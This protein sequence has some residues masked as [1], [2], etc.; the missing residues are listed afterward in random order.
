MTVATAI[1][2]HGDVPDHQT[3]KAI[4]K[5]GL[6]PGSYSL[7]KK[8][9][10]SLIQLDLNKS[11]EQN[12]LNDKDVIYFLNKNV[13]E[14]KRVTSFITKEHSDEKTKKS[15][16]FRSMLH[17]K[18]D[19]EKQD[20]TAKCQIKVFGVPLK[21]AMDPE[22][23]H[24]AD[25]GIP[26]FIEQAFQKIQHND[27]S[28]DFNVENDPHVISGLIKLFLRELPEPLLTFK[29]FK[30]FK[31]L[32][33]KKFIELRRDV[34][35]DDIKA[36]YCKTCLSFLPKENYVFLKR[37]LEFFCA[38]NKFESLNKMSMQNIATILGPNILR[39]ENESGIEIMTN[40]SIVNY[41]VMFM[42]QNFDNLFDKNNLSIPFVGIAEAQYAFEGQGQPSDLVFQ[43]GDILF[44]S[45]C[46]DPHGW[47]AGQNNGLSGSFPY[48]FVK[49]LVQNVSYTTNEESFDSISSVG[50][51]EVKKKRFSRQIE[52][53]E[54][55]SQ[56]P[57]V[58]AKKDEDSILNTLN[59]EVSRRREL[60][61][62][63]NLLAQNYE[64]LLTRLG[65]VEEENKLLKKRIDVIE[66]DAMMFSAPP[67]PIPNASNSSKSIG[68][69]S[70]NH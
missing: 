28:V 15:S 19:K 4:R 62:I 17:S 10:T 8:E 29:L 20:S 7:H 35:S 5:L 21:I 45:D 27:Q 54:L 63:I 60:E 53:E 9:G 67:P 52:P 59:F 69:S 50:D 22:L 3:R 68:K 34:E 37:I 2:L 12:G 32:H 23:N 61:K 56:E 46:C 36:L 55:H 66:G 26:L 48:N 40:T 42:L 70:S 51:D 43:E 33:C 13:K 14:D 24:V 18:R 57:I 38:L 64:M 11:V 25:N 41:V 49:M 31:S 39:P 16:Y 47:W 30:A 44:I 6:V 65:K 58:A 1:I